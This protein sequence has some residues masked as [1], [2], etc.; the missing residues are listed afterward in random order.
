MQGTTWREGTGAGG[1]G[2]GGST[3]M[4][5]NLQPAQ[6]ALLVAKECHN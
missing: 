4:N 3:T 5:E 6:L 1:E 2:D